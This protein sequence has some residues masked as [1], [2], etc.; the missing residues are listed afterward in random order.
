MPR[1]INKRIRRK[2]KQRQSQK[3]VVN[4]YYNRPRRKTKHELPPPLLPSRHSDM[5]AQLPKPATT[6]LPPAPA[7]TLATSIQTKPLVP[8]DDAGRAERANLQ[9]ELR[10]AIKQVVDRNLLTEQQLN[11]IRHAIAAQTVTGREHTNALAHEIGQNRRQIDLVGRIL[12]QTNHA[13]FEQRQQILDLIE[14]SMRENR[15]YAEQQLKAQEDSREIAAMSFQNISDQNLDIIRS[16]AV[17]NQMIEQ[18]VEDVNRQKT[19]ILSL[20]NNTKDEIQNHLT[21]EMH[22]LRAQIENR[23][24]TMLPNQ[25]DQI[26]H[27]LNTFNEQTRERTEQM[28]NALTQQI[29]SLETQLQL[30][31]PDGSDLQGSIAEIDNNLA[32]AKREIMQSVN[33]RLETFQV[34]MAD[35]LHRS[36]NTSRATPSRPLR[37]RL[38]P[39]SPDE[40][41]TMLS[42]PMPPPTPP[43]LETLKISGPLSPLQLA[44][45]Y[46]KGLMT[47]YQRINTKTYGDGTVFDANT[48]RMTTIRMTTIDTELMVSEVFGGKTIFRYI[49]PRDKTNKQVFMQ[50]VYNV[51]KTVTGQEPAF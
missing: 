27:L 41:V 5:L 44:I 35:L 43:D 1:K 13:S 51:Y 49:E 36:L 8:V 28:V 46:E 30:S 45:N 50:A 21:A 3:Q 23:L 22:Q 34:Q 10:S 39:P 31:M 19:Q 11:Q 38:S 32:L 2:M 12:D 15:G 6:L 29:R 25:M 48:G 24:L 37:T 33:V 9:S 16:Q 4:V 42:T 14:R 17:T 20:I 47:S 40:S 7:I 26:E 18:V